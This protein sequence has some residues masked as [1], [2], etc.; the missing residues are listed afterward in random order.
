MDFSA[1][2]EDFPLIAGRPDLVYLDSAAT[3]QKPR[4]VLEALDRYYKELNANVHRGAYRLSVA[5]T[6]AYE[7][8]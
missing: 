5:A 6:E 8:A 2:R 1:L 7:E 3:S 4:R